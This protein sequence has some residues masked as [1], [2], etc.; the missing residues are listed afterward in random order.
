V[1]APNT[2]KGTLATQFHGH[3]W[4]TKTPHEVATLLEDKSL[5][6]V[7]A[8]NPFVVDFFTLMETVRRTPASCVVYLSSTARVITARQNGAAWDDPT[9]ED[10]LSRRT[11]EQFVQ[12]RNRKYKSYS[13]V[14]IS[15][16]YTPIKKCIK[17]IAGLLCQI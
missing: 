4:K 7:I 5:T 16:E 15:T 3:D 8:L 13:D 6:G 1:G 2:G 17:T 11:M 10:W 14:Y 9:M 12:G